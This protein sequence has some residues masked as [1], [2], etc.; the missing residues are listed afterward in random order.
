MQNGSPEGPI[1]TKTN[2]M[3]HATLAAVEML[4]TQNPGAGPVYFA[5]NKLGIRAGV[6]CPVLL[7]RSRQTNIEKMQRQSAG[8]DTREYV[9]RHPLLP[10]IVNASWGRS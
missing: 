1:S 7:L 8:G 5:G 3:A 2:A 9:C 4:I 10:F 6:D